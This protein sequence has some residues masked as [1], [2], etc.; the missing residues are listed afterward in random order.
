MENVLDAVK[1]N[2]F[3]SIAKLA[4]LKRSVVVPPI[5]QIVLAL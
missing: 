3:K 4:P 2:I 5:P 1:K